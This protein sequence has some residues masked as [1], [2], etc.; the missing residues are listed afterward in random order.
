MILNLAA[1]DRV[2]VLFTVT[3][4][5]VTG[6]QKCCPGPLGRRACRRGAYDGGGWVPWAMSRA[7]ALRLLVALR[8]RERLDAAAWAGVRSPAEVAGRYGLDEAAPRYVLADIVREE[9]GD[10]AAEAFLKAYVV[11]E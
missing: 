5:R 6:V 7:V 9:S 1:G 3:R 2:R 10:L 11:S 8:R 4:G